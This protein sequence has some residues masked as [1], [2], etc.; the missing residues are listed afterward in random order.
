MNYC[1]PFNKESK[2]LDTI[3]ELVIDF[4]PE[5][6]EALLQSF[7]DMHPDQRVTL[8][9]GMLG[10]SKE[11]I[12]AVA[13]LR[14]SSKFSIRTDKNNAAALEVIPKL[15]INWYFTNAALTYDDIYTYAE[16]GAKEFFIGPQLGFDLEHCKIVANNLNMKVRSVYAYSV[17][18]SEVYKNYWQFFIRP[19]DIDLYGQYIDTVEF[20]GKTSVINVLVRVYHDKKWDG[21]LSEI[22]PMSDIRFDSRYMISHWG[23]RRINCNRKCMYSSSS[24][25]NICEIIPILSKT[26]QN[27]NIVIPSEIRGAKADQMIIDETVEA[28]ESK[29]K[30]N[31]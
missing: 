29:P 10:P 16:A 7:I 19:E 3:E 18:D 9:I 6:S 5:R 20:Y 15:G 25:C 4:N 14:D 28:K 12:A 31:F 21:P 30:P 26:L 24:T 13:N 17:L 2:Y 23:Q 11:L 8:D 27:A 1:I 22:I